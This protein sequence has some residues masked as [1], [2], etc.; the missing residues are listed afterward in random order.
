MKR[1]SIHGLEMY[2]RVRFHIEEEPGEREL[3]DA[4]TLKRRREILERIEVIDGEHL[5]IERSLKGLNQAATGPGGCARHKDAPHGPEGRT[6]R[7]SEASRVRERSS[8][9]AG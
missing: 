7:A 2:H 4:E 3:I 6:G 9:V 1:R 8:G 5:R